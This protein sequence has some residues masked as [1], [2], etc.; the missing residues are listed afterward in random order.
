MRLVKRQ[1]LLTRIILPLMVTV[2]L[3]GCNLDT[4]PS[5]PA[6]IVVLSGDAQTT[7]V[8][9]ALRDSLA[10]VVVGSYFDPMQGQTVTWTIVAPGGGSLNPLTSLTDQNGI[11]W[12]RY[13]AGA[14]A[15]A[16]QIQAKVGT[17]SP[18]VFNATVTP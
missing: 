12:T 2:A 5:G 7:P 8:N 13:T 4:G 11:A 18:V 9:T 15:G 1:T 3:F 10:V 17:V 14:T 16:V 6:A